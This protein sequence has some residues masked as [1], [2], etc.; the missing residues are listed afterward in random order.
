MD[1]RICE[2][3]LLSEFDPADLNPAVN[4]WIEEG[5]QPL[6]SPSIGYFPELGAVILNQAMVRREDAERMAELEEEYNV[7]TTQLDNAEWIL[8]EVARFWQEIRAAGAAVHDAYKEAALDVHGDESWSGPL[9][10][11]RNREFVTRLAL[12]NRLDEIVEEYGEGR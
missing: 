3:V 10:A 6:G 1:Q 5:W 2:Y 7:L 4:K 9:G 11:A 8:A 12:E